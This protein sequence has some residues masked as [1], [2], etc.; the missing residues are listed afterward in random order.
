MVVPLACIGGGNMA[1]ALLSGHAGPICVAEPDP[2]RRAAFTHGVAT[3]GEAMDWLERAEAAPG[4]GQVMLAIKP[5]MLG[6][7]AAELGGRLARGAGRVVVTM[8]A[9][10]PSV[11][12]ARELGRDDA[13]RVR[14]V[15]IMP[16]TP[17]QVGRG[18]GAIALGANARPG[19]DGLARSILSRS[20]EVVD[21]AESMMDAFTGVAGSG[22]AYVFALCEAMQRAGESLGFAPDDAARIARATVVG[23]AALLDR[24]EDSASVLRERVTSKGGTTE[25][26]LRV[27]RERGLDEIISATVRA[28]R[29]RGAELAGG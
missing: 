17:A 9:G 2:A 12:V 27:L 15:R 11:R 13:G 14:V 6:A 25:A 26:A 10:T 24:S 20:G 28:A 23:A 8:L 19:D 18:M 29:D 22:P 1:R 16:N 4:D 3:A 21:I 7:V 5:Q